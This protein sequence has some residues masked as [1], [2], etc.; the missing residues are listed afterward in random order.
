MFTFSI[1]L[2]LTSVLLIIIGVIIYK[3]NIELIHSYH[4]ENVTDKV[5]YGKAMGKALII[6]SLPLIASGIIAFFTESVIPTIVLIVG[7]VIGFIP[8]IKAQNKYNGGVF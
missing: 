7:M 3:G 4:Q 2:F 6:L 8:I 1:I 5:G